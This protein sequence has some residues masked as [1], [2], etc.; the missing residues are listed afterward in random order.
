MAA[1][2]VDASRPAWATARTA[3]VETGSDGSPSWVDPDEDPSGLS[4]SAKTV[5][6]YLYCE[7][8]ASS[9]PNSSGA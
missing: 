9:G 5:S 2:V 4:E 8:A 7:Q 3:R 6:G 1:S